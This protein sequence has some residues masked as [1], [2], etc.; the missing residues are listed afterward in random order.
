M[1]LD[2]SYDGYRIKYR[3]SDQSF[4]MV[5]P[6]TPSGPVTLELF[7]GSGA[8][9]PS[10]SYSTPSWS[11]SANHLLVCCV[12]LRGTST[13]SGHVTG[14]SGNGLTWTKFL[15]QDDTQNAVSFQ[16]WWAKGA[17]PTAGAVTLS[18]SALTLN[19]GVHLVSFSGIS[20]SPIGATASADNGATD[21]DVVTTSL[22]TT[23]NNS[24]V[25]AFISGRN[26]TVS[27]PGGSLFTGIIMN[28]AFGSGGSIGRRTSLLSSEIVSSG[29]TVTPTF[30]LS[31]VDDW[32]IGAVEIKST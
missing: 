2:I 13:P 23:A 19:L 22:V 17:S 31:A 12:G 11:P 1:P 16:L 26:K 14:V 21:T 24:K 9:A 29:T 7:Q 6:P 10:G 4:V 8:E 27:I 30:N 25:L 3:H 18:L 32:I 20:A 5:A 28:E 15:E